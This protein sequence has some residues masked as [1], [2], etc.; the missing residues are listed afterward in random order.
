MRLLTPAGERPVLLMIFTGGEPNGGSHLFERE[1]T[2]L[3]TKKSHLPGQP[4]CLKQALLY[5]MHQLS[6]CKVSFILAGMLS[7]RGIAHIFG[8]ADRN[9]P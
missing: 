6:L 3:V 1:L 5:A 8:Q 4:D 7:S 2:N 9:A